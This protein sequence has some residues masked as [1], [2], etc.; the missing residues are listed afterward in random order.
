MTSLRIKFAA[1]LGAERFVL[2]DVE[3]AVCH[4]TA[5]LEQVLRLKELTSRFTEMSMLWVHW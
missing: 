4:S 1:L 2:D 3:N 5:S